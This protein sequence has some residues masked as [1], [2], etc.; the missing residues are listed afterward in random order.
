MMACRRGLHRKD[1][2]E[3]VSSKYFGVEVGPVNISPSLTSDLRR[4][5]RIRKAEYE[6]LSIFSGFLANFFGGWPKF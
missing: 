1:N 3:S 5:N 2:L 6:H 4:G